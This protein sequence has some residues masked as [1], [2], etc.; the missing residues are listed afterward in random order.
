RR[1]PRRCARTAD[2][3]PE[4]RCRNDLRAR[5]PPRGLAANRTRG[6]RR[7]RWTATARSAAGSRSS[8]PLSLHRQSFPWVRRAL[9]DLVLPHRGQATRILHM[10]R[11]AGWAVAAL[12]GWLAAAPAHA[13][14]DPRGALLERAGWDAIA[15]GQGAAAAKAFREAL[16]ADPKN[17]RL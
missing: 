8:A 1:R 4:S 15:A 11:F 17:A 3:Q 10:G 5:R 12:V 7:G 2:L 13:Q 6:R 16:A 14:I 9:R